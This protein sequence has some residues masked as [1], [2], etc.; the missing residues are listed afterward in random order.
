[1]N[2]N[3]KGWIVFLSG[4]AMYLAVAFFNL[5]F[6]EGCNFTATLILSVTWFTLF[7]AAV[8]LLVASIVLA[9]AASPMYFAGYDHGF[10]VFVSLLAA[11]LGIFL[12]NLSSLFTRGATDFASAM[13]AHSLWHVFWKPYLSAFAFSFLLWALKTIRDWYESI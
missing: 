2:M 12:G 10:A 3:V 1:M 7:V 8:V 4:C 11:G 6:G 13:S 9:V 5:G